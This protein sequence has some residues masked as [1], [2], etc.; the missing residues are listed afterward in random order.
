MIQVCTYL[1]VYKATFGG[2]S[3]GLTIVRRN[4]CASHL[5]VSFLESTAHA[6]LFLLN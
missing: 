5:F 2:Y 4:V 3:A 6:N 1:V